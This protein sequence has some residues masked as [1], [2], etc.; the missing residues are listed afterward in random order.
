MVA[1]APRPRAAM[2]PWTATISAAVSA[3]VAAAITTAIGPAAPRCRHLLLGGRREQRLAGEADLAGVGLDTHNLDLDFVAQLEEVRDLTA[4]A[5][6][7]LGDVQQPVLSG[8]ELDECAV[9][10]D[11]LV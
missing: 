9:R 4:A 8:K 5:V 2:T 6:R 7:H 10:A 11:A 3:T 1:A